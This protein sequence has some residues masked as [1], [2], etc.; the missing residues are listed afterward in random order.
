MPDVS[1]VVRLPTFDRFTAS[2]DA[3]VIVT[4]SPTTILQFD[5]IDFEV[6][7]VIIA[8]AQIPGRKGLTAGEVWVQ[9]TNIGGFGL[10]WTGFYSF[11]RFTMP[12][13]PARAFYR[14]LIMAEATSGFDVAVTVGIEGQSQGSDF[15]IG[16]GNA[17]AGLFRIR[18]IV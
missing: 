3:Q 15:T 10:N 9:L 5:P 2:N 12:N 14:P 6:D 7:D 11:A 17:R 1:R 13:I 4:S 18:P 8:S 16:L